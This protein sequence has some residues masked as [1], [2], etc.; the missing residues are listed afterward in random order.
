MGQ[1][2]ASWIE[3]NEGLIILILLVII[4]RI[5]SLFEP[6]WYGDEGIYLVLGQG[7]RKGLILY[8]DIHD[9][10]PPL[11]YILA[12]V[13]QNVFYFRLMLMASM[14]V[15]TAIFFRIS[16]L[17][18]PR[19]PKAWYVTTL[20]M[21]GLTTVFEGN[22][23][24]AEIFSVLPITLGMLLILQNKISLM[25]GLIFSLGVLLK[26]PAG[27][28]WVAAV[29][30]LLLFTKTKL[31]DKRV[32][33]MTLGVA[34]PIVGSLIYYEL[35]GGGEPY[36]RSALLQ[37][38]GYLA[39]WNTGEHSVSG[40]TSQ[41]GLIIRTISLLA[42]LSG[43]WW[44]NKKRR[45]ATGLNLTVI[46]FA[47]ALFG[48]LLSERPY[49]HYLVQP[50]VPLAILLGWLI[51]SRGK[52]VKSLIIAILGVGILAYLKIGFW[53]YPV[54]SYYKNFAEY[55]FGVKNKEAY[56]NFFDNRVEQTYRI[57]DYI[58]TTTRP[59]EKLFIWGDEPY[60]YALTNRLPAGRYTVAYHVIDFNGF[61]ETVKAIEKNKPKIIIV[62]KYENRKFAELQAILA[63]QY[64]LVKNI[65]Q[66]LIYKR[67]I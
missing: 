9:N 22:I 37:N 14:I 32:W 27:A 60:I 59:E 61:G 40:F 55:A 20:V 21:V 49:P 56:R 4:L 29:I 12:A 16:Q 48:S 2:L 24:N 1:K 30:W 53:Q 54:F 46:W 65:D 39:S 34:A 17:M 26:V 67:L 10:K 18:F 33:L 5:P 51:F 47:W 38:F 15:A 7:I 19:L 42:G 13:A 52:I 63:N 58:R 62:M 8:R 31:S 23:S 45:F 64:V 3:K 41:K 6:Y 36:L 11:L 43:W 25:T 35:M 57:S 44:L 50:A 28:D 66:A